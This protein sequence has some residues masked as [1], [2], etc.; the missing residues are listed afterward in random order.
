MSN[1]RE[2]T[3][4]ENPRNYLPLTGL[5]L[6]THLFESFTVCPSNGF[7]LITRHCRA[8][9][10]VHLRFFVVARL[11]HPLLEQAFVI[12]AYSSACVVFIPR[13]SSSHLL[14]RIR[15]AAVYSFVR[16][17]VARRSPGSLLVSGHQP[18]THSLCLRAISARALTISRLFPV[19]VTRYTIHERSRTE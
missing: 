18:R 14:G 10:C 6:N 13:R 2:T 12:S 5:I 3:K 4:G 16:R 17:D 7:C 15:A 1:Q 11:S 8:R 9:R 19:V